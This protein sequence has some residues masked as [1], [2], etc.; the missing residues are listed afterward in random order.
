MLIIP[1]PESSLN[2]EAGRL[3]QDNYLE[4]FKLAKLYTSI[5]SCLTSATS[6]LLF[7]NKLNEN[8][9]RSNIINN[10][11]LHTNNKEQEK[12]SVLSKN[13]MSEI[14]LGHDI[15]MESFKHSKSLVMNDKNSINIVEQKL[16][17][18]NFSRANSLKVNQTT[19]KTKQDEIKKWL[20]RI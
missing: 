18:N 9:N 20:S 4:Y 10:E 14:Y 5:H 3:F 2:E 16:N 13:M 1:F 7:N 11:Y 15:E 6:N 8:N 17:L 19:S 12:I